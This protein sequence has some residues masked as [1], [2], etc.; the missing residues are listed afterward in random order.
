MESVFGFGFCLLFCQQPTLV[1]GRLEWHR[2]RILNTN[3]A[4]LIWQL[5]FGDDADSDYTRSLPVEYCEQWLISLDGIYLHDGPRLVSDPPYNGSIVL[6]PGGRANMMIRCNVSGTYSV[7]ASNNTRNTLFSNAPVPDFTTIVMDIYVEE[8]SS[9]NDTDLD[10][11]SGCRTTA[12]CTGGMGG[13]GLPC[14]FVPYDWSPYLAP[15]ENLT[16]PDV[17]A[18]CQTVH[19]H[20]FNQM[21]EC[22]IVLGHEIPGGGKQVTVNHIGFSATE[23]LLN[24]ATD[25]THEWMITSNFHEFHQHI[26]PYQLQTDVVQGWLAQVYYL[27]IHLK[28]LHCKIKNVIKLNKTHKIDIFRSRIVYVKI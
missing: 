22:N 3:M 7:I 15:T 10:Y 16:Y 9:S 19:N 12:D 6:P 25:V 26:W 14:E 28:F 27:K 20:A 23:P 5:N 1:I 2:L 4:Y 18:A 13:S 24:L 11:Y 21:T 17:T 8:N